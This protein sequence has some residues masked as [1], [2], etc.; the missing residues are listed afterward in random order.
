MISHI[1]RVRT[2]MRTRGAF[3][4][5]RIR[6]FW[7]NSVIPAPPPHTPPWTHDMHITRIMRI[8]RL[9]RII[10]IIP[11]IRIMRIMRITHIT[12]YARARGTRMAGSQSPGIPAPR[13][14][15]NSHGWE[16]CEIPRI[17]GP[18]VKGCVWTSNPPH[19]PLRGGGGLRPPP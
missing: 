12:F 15:E 19:P 1:S 9:I 4:G 11:I 7:G 10:R 2:H 6:P 14:L 3:L 8:I 17:R 13:I 18:G 16:P 5:C